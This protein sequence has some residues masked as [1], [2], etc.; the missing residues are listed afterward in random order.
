MPEVPRRT[1][2]KNP[3]TAAQVFGT[4]EIAKDARRRVDRHL[5]QLQRSGDISRATADELMS[6]ITEAIRKAEIAHVTAREYDFERE[7]E[8][9]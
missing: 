3:P 2:I 1:W 9:E 8:N 4:A 7:K 6:E 5:L